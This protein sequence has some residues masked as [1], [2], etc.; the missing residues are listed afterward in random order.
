M[1]Q[2]PAVL[3]ELGGNATTECS[4]DKGGFYFYMLWFRQLSGGT[5]EL[6]VSTTAGQSEHEFGAFSQEKFS[7]TK[8]GV[9]RG[10]LTVKNVQPEDSGGYFCAVSRH[11]DAEKH[12]S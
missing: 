10:T 12:G 4:H 6:I 3:T 2:T 11:S 9:S 7:A 5:I 1:T 8:A